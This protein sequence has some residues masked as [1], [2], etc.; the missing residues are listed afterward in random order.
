VERVGDAGSYDFL[1]KVG[2]WFCYA[3]RDSWDSAVCAVACRQA[4]NADR[5]RSELRN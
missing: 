2:N 3:A 5:K 4:L 1:R